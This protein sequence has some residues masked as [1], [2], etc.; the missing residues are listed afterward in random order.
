MF[1]GLRLQDGVIRDKRRSRAD[2]GTISEPLSGAFRHG[3]PGLRFAPPG[4]TRSG[5]AC[6][7]THP[8]LVVFGHDAAGASV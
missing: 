4:M 3:I 6:S 5:K 8:L 1:K 2:P 7:G